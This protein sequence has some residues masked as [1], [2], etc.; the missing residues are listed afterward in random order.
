MFC[1]AAHG[2]HAGPDVRGDGLPQEQ[3]RRHPEHTQM[4][5]RRQ[6]LGEFILCWSEIDLSRIFKNYIYKKI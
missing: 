3:T 1:N 4:E 2:V 5:E 6:V